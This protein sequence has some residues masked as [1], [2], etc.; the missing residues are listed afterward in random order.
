MT[1][2]EVAEMAGVSE[3][4]VRKNCAADNLHAA[5][6]IGKTLG[7]L[8]ADVKD[9]M[10]WREKNPRYSRAWGWND[11]GTPRPGGKTIKKKQKFSNEDYGEGSP[12]AP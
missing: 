8:E 2:A 7:F 6:Q 5:G 1:V 3:P 11:S 10:D 9:W 4:T 12:E